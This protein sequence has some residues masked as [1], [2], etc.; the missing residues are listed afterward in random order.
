MTGP[1]EQGGEPIEQGDSTPI[2]CDPE[3]PE[4]RMDDDAIDAWAASLGE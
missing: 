4:W 3:M 1:G 2:D